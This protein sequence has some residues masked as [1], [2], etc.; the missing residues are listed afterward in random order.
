MRIVP[1]LKD[2][3]LWGP[4]IQKAFTDMGVI[5]LADTDI[6]A[7]MAEDEQVAEQL[8]RRSSP[9]SARRG[10]RRRGLAP[11]RSGVHVRARAVLTA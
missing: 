2:I 1:I 3:G 6:D 10:G 5:A 11:A 7:A 8:D 9:A 4:R